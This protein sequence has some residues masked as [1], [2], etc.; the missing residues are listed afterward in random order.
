MLP[1]GEAK[2]P[3]MP[4]LLYH[5]ANARWRDISSMTSFVPLYPS[6]GET[7][8]DAERLTAR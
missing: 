2:L 3:E 4:Q 7:F 1:F 8:G 6:P 5:L